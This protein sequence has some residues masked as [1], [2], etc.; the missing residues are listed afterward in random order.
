V[1]GS[2]DRVP[3]T[4][5]S[6]THPENPYG[7]TKL[8]IEEILQTYDAAYGLKSVCLRY[9]NAAGA[10]PD[11]TMGDDHNHKTHLISVALAHALGQVTTMTIFGTDYPTPDGTAIRDY[12][13]V[14]DLARAHL[15]ALDFLDREQRSDVFNLG[16]EQGHSV[17]EV[18]QQ[19]EA[20]TGKTLTVIEGPRRPGD[21]AVLVA[22]NQKARNRLGWTPHYTDLGA[23]IKTA[24]A[25]L[26]THPN[27]YQS[28][29]MRN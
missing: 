14:D 7:L 3:I 20:V 2:P 22:A 21:P 10:D 24:W 25:W 9:F 13:H 16:T 28:T 5:D 1:Y 29:T 12:I 6:P 19:V 23:T 11:G 18:L 8:Q 17:R 4:E 15:R 26:Q 27:G